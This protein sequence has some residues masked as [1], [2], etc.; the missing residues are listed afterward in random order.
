MI[1]FEAKIRF[2]P[3]IFPP[4]KPLQIVILPSVS[5]FLVGW[6]N[7]GS[8]MLP[9]L[10]KVWATCQRP[11]ISLD[12]GAADSMLLQRRDFTE[13]LNILSQFLSLCAF[14]NNVWQRKRTRKSKGNQEHFTIISCWTHVSRWSSLTLS[15]TRSICQTR[16]WWSS[17]LHGGCS[18]V[19]VRWS[20]RIGWKRCQGQQKKSN[21]SSS[22]PTRC[23]KRWRAQQND[24]W[25]HYRFWWCLAEHSRC[26]LAEKQ[27]R[28]KEEIQINN[29]S[30]VFFCCSLNSC[31]HATRCLSTP[32]SPLWSTTT[33]S[34]Y[35]QST[36]HRTIEILTTG[37]WKR[38]NENIQSILPGL[39]AKP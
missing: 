17:R 22:H 8:H 15:S 18:R 3:I 11:I 27:R 30:N 38:T 36:Y 24:V 39:P 10:T 31:I 7:C 16:W 23:A 4:R 12:D 1:I 25:R 35:H 33:I 28:Q 21:R 6:I 20:S 5:R 19:P 26:S 9:S 2:E 34:I 14:K 37:F 13:L 32:P 29:N